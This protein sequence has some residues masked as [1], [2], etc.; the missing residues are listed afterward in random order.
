[1][2]SLRSAVSLVAI[3]LCVL[4]SSVASA[5]DVS[6]TRSPNQVTIAAP[7]AEERVETGVE[8]TTAVTLR[9]K[10]GF[11]S[12]QMAGD[13]TFASYPNITW[14]QDLS[15]IS[16]T[17]LCVQ[18]LRGTTATNV[19]VEAWVSKQIPTIGGNLT[20]T[21]IASFYLGTI[22]AGTTRCAD[23]GAVPMTPPS[24][25]VYWATAALYEG[26]GG[27]RILQQLYTLP[28]QVDFG[29]PFY[30]GSL[31]FTTPSTYY[32]TNGGSTASIQLNRIYN[33]TLSTTRQ[34]RLMLF[35]SSTIP[36]WDQT[37]SGYQIAKK[38]YN[39]LNSGYYYYNVD[40]GSLAVTQP[41]AGT[42]WIT[43]FL[44]Q[45][46]SDGKWYYYCL[47][48]YPT[49]YAFT[50]AAPA[51]VA[52]FTY[53]PASPQAGQTVIFTDAST[54]SPTSW[55]WNFGDGGTSTASSPSH[56][57]T[58]SGV[59]TVSLTATNA[60]GWDTM[61]K[62]IVVAAAPSAPVITYFG[63]N[64]SSVSSGQQT[65]LTWTST[66]GTAA[67]IDQGVGGVPTS[68]SKT[69]TPVTG[70]PYR[71]TVSGP[72][73]STSATVTI[74]AVAPSYAGAW[75]LPSSARVQGA[76]AFWT[77]DLTVANSGTSS[78]S[79][80]IK[81]LGHEGSGVSG[82]ERFYTIPARGTSTW[83]DVL[84]LMFTRDADYGPILIRSTSTSIVAQG[85]TW[86]AS[87]SGGSY[88]QS[89]PAISAAEAAGTTPRTIAGVRQDAQFRTNIVLANMKESEAAVALTVLL[90][91]GTIANIYNTTLG[92]LGFKQVNLANDLGI[93]NFSGGSVVV[94]SSTNGAQVAAYAS[95]ID[96]TTADPRTILAR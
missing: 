35:A 83:P 80:A 7:G 11:M 79:V 2:P 55:S 85:Q 82:Q 64:P 61:T 48:T 19:N 27:S 21:T 71:L 14:P 5:G 94:S 3:A 88:G 59:F 13:L 46:G 28:D 54:G 70:V 60:G 69:I 91:D 29:G 62:T 74:G 58:V 53:S 65:T 51:P 68:G 18:N 22:P 66:G 23:T 47:Y 57:Y 12:Q 36:R 42:Y 6:T 92:P 44:Q 32:I 10:P 8:G 95:V 73:G 15:T 81:F 93:T 39:P 75:V 1:M 30:T 49:Q 40:T 50:G 38:D 9:G 26:T 84:G 34:L 24:P 77:T 17:N 63:A 96:S 20:H 67:T 78:T 37:I 43:T 4:F 87:P 33:N 52:D 41:P 90:S 45:L 16:A 56:T 76:G 89:V 86:T 25:D 31:Y 72:G